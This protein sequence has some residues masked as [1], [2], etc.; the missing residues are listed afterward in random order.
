MPIITESF[1]VVSD[2]PAEVQAGAEKWRFT[3]KS[4]KSGYVD[5]PDEADIQRRAEAEIPLE[6]VSKEWP[7]GS[8]P[9]KHAEAIQKL[10][11]A[12]ATHVFIHSPEPDQMRAIQF[13]GQQVL[14]MF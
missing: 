8:D 9:Q 14:P 11:Q 4:W 12:G 5:N 10:I 7:T 3:K 2:D 1:V 13:Y 6:D